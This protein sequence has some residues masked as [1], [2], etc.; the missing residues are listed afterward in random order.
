MCP[1]GPRPRAW[2]AF[3]TRPDES[4]AEVRRQRPFLSADP[5]PVA[6]NHIHAADAPGH[7]TRHRPAGHDVHIVTAAT[8]NKPNSSTKKTKTSNSPRPRRTG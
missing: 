5:V 2:R 6:S 7:P 1:S 8:S 4:R 3:R